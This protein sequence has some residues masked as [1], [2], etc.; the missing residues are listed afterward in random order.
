MKPA[1]DAQKLFIYRVGKLADD[2]N[3]A[4]IEGVTK[5]FGLINDIDTTISE[6]DISKLDAF[7]Y[8]ESQRGDQEPRA[9]LE[10]VTENVMS[11][12]KKE[13][14]GTVRK[15]LNEYRNFLFH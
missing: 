6:K 3:R 1:T 9:F 12:T 4:V 13:D 2:K 8:L 14:F 15:A 10:S 5:A 11:E 7:T